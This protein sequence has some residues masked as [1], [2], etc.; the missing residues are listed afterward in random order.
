MLRQ[1]N[2]N[3]RRAKQ[4]T[5]PYLDVYGLQMIGRRIRHHVKDGFV[6]VCFFSSK[7]KGG[8]QPS[9]DLFF[10]G[11]EWEAQTLMRTHARI[12]LHTTTDDLQPISSTRDDFLSH[13]FFD[14]FVN[15]RN[16]NIDY[17]FIYIDCLEVKCNAFPFN[18]LELGVKEN[19]KHNK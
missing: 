6:I 14:S 9:D 4:R 17:F 19:V 13:S 3:H 1:H 5:N 7:A 2:H 8:P 12:W 10:G 18:G 11:L 15:L 16:K